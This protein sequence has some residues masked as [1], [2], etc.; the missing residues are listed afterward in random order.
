MNISSS[1]PLGQSGHLA[2]SLSAKQ[3]EFKNKI[4]DDPQV[5]E[6][7]IGGSA[8]GPLPVRTKVATPTGMKAIGSLEIGDDILD[9]HGGVAKVI[10]IPYEGKDECRWLHFQDGVRIPCS[11]NHLWKVATREETERGKFRILT[12]EEIKKELKQHPL[13]VPLPKPACLTPKVEELP[14][15]PYLLGTLFMQLDEVF[16]SKADGRSRWRFYCHDGIILTKCLE[17]LGNDLQPYDDARYEFWLDEGRT[18]KLLKDVV[19]L[20]HFD[21]YNG[22]FSMIRMGEKPER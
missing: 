10:D 8:G 13:Y 12:A 20:N 14:L 9:V 7:L 5:V 6:A 4:L 17:I 1:N 3:V 18:K 22:H 16:Y 21:K 19:A 11:I 15:H 2:L